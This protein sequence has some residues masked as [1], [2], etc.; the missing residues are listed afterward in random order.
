MYQHTEHMFWNSGA[1]F[2]HKIH[3]NHVII[4]LRVSI[5]TSHGVHMTGQ[6]QLQRSGGQVPDL[7]GSISW[8]S[9]EP[10]VGRIHRDRSDPTQMTADNAH[11][12]PWCVPTTWFDKTPRKRT[13]EPQYT[14]FDT[15]LTY[16]CMLFCV[17]HILQFVHTYHHNGREMA[18]FSSGAYIS[19]RWCR[20]MTF[21][22]IMLHYDVCIQNNQLTM[23]DRFQICWCV[24]IHLWAEIQ[25]PELRSISIPLIGQS[26]EDDERSHRQHVTPIRSPHSAQHHP[27]THDTRLHTGIWQPRETTSRVR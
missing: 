19:S 24:T 17:T 23:G 7:H 1:M 8:T 4:L 11:E 26:C 10:L 15:T 21:N 25:G 16:Q 22:T 13:F 12:L 3:S 14:D 5:L 2:G 6:R 20:E 27:L 18:I 9:S